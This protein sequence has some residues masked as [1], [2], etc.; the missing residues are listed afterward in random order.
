MN[1]RFYDVNTMRANA[2]KSL[3]EVRSQ[4]DVLV[5]YKPQQ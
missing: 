5:G 2:A 4:E 3:L 1:C